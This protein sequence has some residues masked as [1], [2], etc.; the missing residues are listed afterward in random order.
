[1]PRR[2]L[3]LCVLFVFT[4]T[5]TAAWAQAIATSAGERFTRLD[6]N[7]DGGLSRYEMDAEVILRALDRDGDHRISPA[8]LRPLLG[9]NA[10]EESTLD[11]V[12]VADRNADDQLDAGELDRAGLMRF[13][14]IDGNQDGVVD[15]Q[16]LLTRFG[17]HMFNGP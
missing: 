5:A 6:V 3:S 11:R 8:E 16:E 12:R 14:W 7:H 9:A 4:C 13:N 15:Q 17:M 1:M 10:T 2:R